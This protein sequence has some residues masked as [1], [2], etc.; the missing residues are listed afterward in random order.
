MPKFHFH[1]DD[2]TLVADGDGTDLPDLEAAQSEAVK[3]AGELL[4]ELDGRLWQ[5]DKTWLMHVTDENDT[6][7]FSLNFSAK[8]SAGHAKYL[9]VEEQCK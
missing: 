4:R 9:P 6:L 2:G 3:A 1:V 7:L 8:V 5:G